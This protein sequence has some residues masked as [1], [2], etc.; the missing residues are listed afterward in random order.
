MNTRFPAS[1]RGTS[2]LQLEPCGFG[3]GGAGG[4]AGS[5]RWGWRTALAHAEPWQVGAVG[6]AL[7]GNAQKAKG[8]EFFGEQTRCGCAGWWLSHAAV[9]GRE[10]FPPVNPPA[11]RDVEML[12]AKYRPE[13]LLSEKLMNE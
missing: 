12:L 4:A 10:C 3:Y 13:L 8:L 9:L 11:G 6:Q 5:P 2:L 7:V 1:R